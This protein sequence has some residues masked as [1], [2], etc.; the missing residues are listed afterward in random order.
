MTTS[1]NSIIAASRDEDIRE[2]LAA[3]ATVVGIKE[4][5]WF[6]DN[7][8]SRL[9]SVGLSESGDT[10]ASVYEY[11]TANYAPKPRPGEDP[12]LVTDALLIAA[13]RAVDSEVSG[14]EVS[15]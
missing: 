1:L 5:R 6:V 13:V 3:A 11:A 7:H 14:P 12:T 15:E 10:L 8:V 9:V 2:R 4:P